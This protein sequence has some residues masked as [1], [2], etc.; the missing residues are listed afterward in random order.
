LLLE[1]FDLLVQLGVAHVAKNPLEINPL[2]DRGKMRV[3]IIASVGGKSEVIW[4]ACF[5]MEGRFLPQSALV[6]PNRLQ[7]LKGCVAVSNLPI[8]KHL[9]ITQLFRVL[10]R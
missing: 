7:R 6:R 8:Q 1:L 3:R 5:S 2:P 9:K 10:L 4:V